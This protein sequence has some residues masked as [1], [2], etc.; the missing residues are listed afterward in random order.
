[1][2]HFQSCNGRVPELKVIGIIRLVIGGHEAGDDRSENVVPRDGL[3]TVFFELFDTD[4]NGLPVLLFSPERDFGNTIP[5]AKPVC[6]VVL[7]HAHHHDPNARRFVYLLD[8]REIGHDPPAEGRVR[9]L[10]LHQLHNSLYYER[11]V[12]TKSIAT[13]LALRLTFPFVSDKYP[14]AP[15]S[16]H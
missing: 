5:E 9:D 14:A 1:M 8:C 16:S 12:H 2:D 6:K 15:P 10:P 3:D 4:E 13:P 11:D 7:H